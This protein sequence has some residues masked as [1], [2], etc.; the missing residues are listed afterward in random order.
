MNSTRNSLTSPASALGLIFL[1]VNLTSSHVFFQ[2]NSY[3]LV[4]LFVGLLAWWA[5]ELAK[6]RELRPLAPV[7][8]AAPLLLLLARQPGLL[9]SNLASNYYFAYELAGQVMLLFW[10]YLL[11]QALD[12][13]SD[14]RQFARFL[15]LALALGAGWAIWEFP[16][17]VGTGAF[18]QSSFGHRNYLSSFMILLLPLLL[19]LARPW[20][21]RWGMAPAPGWQ[22]FYLV[23]F[24]L[25]LAAMAMAQTRAAIAAL[26]LALVLFW[27][28]GRRLQA[29]NS[30]LPP[31]RNL[32]LSLLGLALVAGAVLWLFN[33]QLP[34]NRFT[35]LFTAKA[36]MTR[37][38]PWEAAW[39]SI[40][41]SPW[42]GYGLGS[43]YSLYFSHVD[44]ASLLLHAERSYNHAHS[45]LL[46]QL[47]EGG[48]LGLAAG[49]FFLLVLLQ[50]LHRAWQKQSREGRFL[51]LGIACGLLAYVLHGLFEVAPRMLVTQLPAYALLAIL[52]RL[53]G[54]DY[55]VTPSAQQHRLGGFLAIVLAGGLLLPWVYDQARFARAERDL[56]SGNSL[57]EQR[58]FQALQ[59]VATSTNDIYAL[60]LLSRWQMQRGLGKDLLQT[61]Q[62][63]D[64]LIPHYR[65]NDYYLA[66]ALALERRFDEAYA[67]LDRNLTF[68]QYHLPSLRMA[69]SLALEFG[70]QAD[71]ERWLTRLV[72]RLAY[73]A[74]LPPQWNHQGVKV[75]LLGMTE[76]FLITS[77]K[78]ALE[79]ELPRHYVNRLYQ[80]GRFY[81][82]QPQ[83]QAQQTAKG[84]Q[85]EFSRIL[86][87]HP[88][89]Q[90]PLAE[91]PAPEREKFLKEINEFYLREQELLRLLQRRQESPSSKLDA[92]VAKAQ[93]AVEA[94]EDR[95]RQWTDWDQYK[96]RQKFGSSLIR[97]LSIALFP[98]A[99]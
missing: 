10:L 80:E 95:L 90:P 75:Y 5:W 63:I 28:V 48:A 7:W 24:G 21:W 66:A 36:W 6:P 40:R 29:G 50:A 98:G 3:K 84:F 47:Q 11:L 34:H 58:G 12:D 71:F 51:A 13:L 88:Y 54:A 72:T 27:W 32:L 92:H 78:G 94:V 89:F 45:E 49:L 73:E 1:W 82:S 65:E 74:G 31:A 22:R 2:V 53:A 46:E 20:D 77:S 96:K 9:V 18:V 33:S 97:E 60:D 26:L 64:L 61:T 25:G 56:M 30:P 15:A 16:G 41:Q 70:Y 52:F 91:V 69:M 81:R 67:Q 8:L 19:A 76:D 55:Q 93:E 87:S 43:S 37:L 57:A 99:T 68:N 44:P 35:A 4:L 62:R 85:A 83:P 79:I 39:N 17:V 42:L 59:Q 86:A 38:N 23:A 14:I